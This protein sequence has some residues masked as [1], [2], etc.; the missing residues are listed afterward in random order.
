M[1]MTALPFG[2]E[3]EPRLKVAAAIPHV[4][5][6]IEVRR[7]LG[8]AAVAQRFQHARI[9]V[10]HARASASVRYSDGSVSR[11]GFRLAIDIVQTPLPLARLQK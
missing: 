10:E 8:R 11:L 9:D 6:E 1:V 7:S 3:F 4:A 2:R 5:A